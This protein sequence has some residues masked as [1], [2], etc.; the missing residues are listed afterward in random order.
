MA[1]LGRENRDDLNYSH[2]VTRPWFMV[3]VNRD[4][5]RSKSVGPVLR[6]PTRPGGGINAAD[7]RHQR[8]D[9]HL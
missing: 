7:F 3:R 4:F 5:R 9:R 6:Q 1:A 2:T 8:V